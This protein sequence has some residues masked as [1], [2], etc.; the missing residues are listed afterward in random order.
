MSAH[1]KAQRGADYAPW[2]QESDPR[3]QLMARLKGE[4]RDG[5]T[6]QR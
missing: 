3:G 6:P 5:A 1:G 4:A 2:Q